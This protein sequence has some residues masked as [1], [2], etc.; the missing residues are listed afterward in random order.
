M[1]SVRQVA[2]WLGNG[3]PLS[4]LWVLCGSPSVYVVYHVVSK[5]D[6][7]HIRP[8]F[9]YKTPEEFDQDLRFLTA[10]AW[11]V[12]HAELPCLGAMMTID[13]G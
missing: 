9:A 3:M 7:P 8:L 12:R 2:R 5:R 11:L 4:W 10:H 6:L 1:I 13:D